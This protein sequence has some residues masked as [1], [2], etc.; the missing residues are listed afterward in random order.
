[1][2]DT[3]DI[4]QVASLI[5]DRARAD[6]LMALMADRALT[7]TELSSVAGVT[8]QTASTHLSRLVEAGLVV[9]SQQGRQRFFRLAADDVV[10]LVERLMAVAF[11][12]GATQVRKPVGTPAL[13]KARLCYDHMAGDL[14]VSAFDA[15]LMRGWFSA[16]PGML[17]L[18]PT[19]RLGLE[20]IGIMAENHDTGRRPLCRMC[21]DWG[22]GRQHLSGAL[23]AII[24]DH[25]LTEGWAEVDAERRVLRFS[26]DGEDAFRASFLLE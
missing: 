1:M 25:V 22:E 3:P 21:A 2:K 6:M 17:E 12:I 16:R 5:G 8:R 18:T 20:G 13:A 9:M 4:A 14:A 10:E 19:G 15:M 26:D 23:G 11:R 24:L 7:A